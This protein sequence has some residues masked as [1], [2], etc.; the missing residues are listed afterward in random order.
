MAPYK[1]LPQDVTALDSIGAAS[2]FN[3]QLRILKAQVFDIK[4]PRL[5]S[6]FLIPVN[7]EGTPGDTHF[8][9]RIFDFTGIAKTISDY[10]SDLP[11]VGVYGRKETTE[12]RDVGAAFNFSDKEIAASKK[13]GVSLKS[14][15]V[16]AVRKVIDTKIDN[17]NWNGEQENNIPG[18]L[19]NQDITWSIAPD[20]A[21]SS[22]LWS[23]KTF[24]E[25]LADLNNLVGGIAILTHGVEQPDTLVMSQAAYN[26]VSTKTRE[27]GSSNDTTVLEF[28][29]KTHPEIK[30]VEKLEVCADAARYRTGDGNG[31]VFAYEKS[32]DVLEMLINQGVTFHKAERRNLVWRTNVTAGYGGVVVYLPLA[33]SVMEGI[34]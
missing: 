27:G 33:I 2:F 21:A 4:Y 14:K 22:T 7:T 1:Y 23:T 20:G 15:K 32:P 25:I 34:A 30:Q 18:L 5:K 28:F 24:D 8:E 11:T 3:E 13:A 17:V 16:N 29:L 26:V 19:S 12:Y 6:F 9:Y 31:V 10:A